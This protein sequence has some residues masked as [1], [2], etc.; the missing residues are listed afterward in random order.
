MEQAGFSL[1]FHLPPYFF[2][3]CNAPGENFNNRTRFSDG[4]L[5]CC[6][7]WIFTDFQ[8]INISFIFILA[9]GPAEKMPAEC[10]LALSSF[11]A[12]KLVHNENLLIE[13]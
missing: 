4:E 11:W 6:R 2:R 12:R 7:R 13:S 3:N 1:F 10:E 8:R 5:Y 9:K